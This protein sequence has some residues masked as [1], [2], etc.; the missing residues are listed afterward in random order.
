MNK[1]NNLELFYELMFY[2]KKLRKKTV[3]EY[4]KKNKIEYNPVEELK[5]CLSQ[6]KN[7]PKKDGKYLLKADSNSEIKM[8]IS[9]EINEMEKDIFYLEHSETE[10]FDY[11]RSIH[12]NFDEQVKKGVEFLKNARIQNFITD[13]DGTINN[14]CGRYN[15]SIQSVYNAIFLTRFA[16]SIPN[17]SVILTSAPL[18]NTGLVNISVNPDN[19]FIYAG[20][21]GREYYDTQ[22]NYHSFPIEKDKAE[23][24]KELNVKLKKL[25]SK[26]EYHKFSLIGSGLQLKY[27]QTTIARQ[28]IYQSVP[29]DE[30]KTF[31]DKIQSIINEVDKDNK[32][33]RIEDTGMD[34]EIIL[35]VSDED[36]NAGLKDYDKGNGVDFINGDL[37]MNIE[38]SVNLVCG[39]TNSDVPMVAY[40]MSKNENTFTIFVTEKEELRNKVKNVCERSLFVTEPDILVTILNRSLIKSC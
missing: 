6:L 8:D 17:N 10:F 30:T 40:S 13:R 23:K 4:F 35:T 5:K 26:E 12:K 34:I 33:F 37:K 16:K 20:S 36:D 18:E 2:T 3:T 31:S 32:Y 11:L 28:D 14:Y 22:D 19:V 1:I 39:D 25:V 27:G 29:E 15:S 9:Y 21:K 7:I 24:L 38:N